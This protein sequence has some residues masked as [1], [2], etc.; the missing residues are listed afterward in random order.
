MK[1]D[2]NFHRKTLA[3][4]LADDYIDLGIDRVALFSQRQKGKTHFCTQDLIPEMQN[5]GYFCIYVDFWNKKDSPESSLAEATEQAYEDLN[6]LQRPF[7]IEG[8]RLTVSQGTGIKAQLGITPDSPMAAEQA[9]RAIRWIL[10][11]ASRQPVFMVLDEIQHLTTQ[12]AF[13][14]FVAKLRSLLVNQAPRCKKPIKALFIGSD[15]TKMAEMFKQTGAPFYRASNLS[16]FEDLGKD[17]TN[18]VVDCFEQAREPGKLDRSECFR[19]FNEGGRLP[20]AFISLLQKMASSKR[21]DLAESADEFDYFTDMEDIYRDQLSKLREQDILILSLLAK[22]WASLYSDEGIELI[23]QLLPQDQTTSRSSIQGS[24]KKLRRYGL[25][26]SKERGS[27]FIQ[28][29]SLAHW[30][31]QKAHQIPNPE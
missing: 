15:Q 14:P 17:F 11:V 27:W 23:N 6:L 3:K 13:D 19:L 28:D 18:H 9:D 30:I 2:W 16:E 25:I 20:G 21:Y 26:A 22:G 7:K 24:I 29:P 10:K 12:S 5:R 4:Q 31:R 1:L 8:F